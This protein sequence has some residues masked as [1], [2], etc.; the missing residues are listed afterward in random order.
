MA[1]FASSI[2]SAKDYPSLVI[3]ALQLVELLL[4]KVP[5]EYKHAFRREGVFHEIETL[6]ARSLV[7]PKVKDKDKDK[8]KDSNEATA[9]AEISTPSY[10]PPSAALVAIPGYKKPSSSTI[11]PDDAI[12]LRARVIK[13]KYLSS[14]EQDESDD[15][16]T[17]L[18]RLVARISDKAASE[19]DLLPSL[20]ELASL[21]ASPNTSVSSFELLQSG[22]VDSLLQFLADTDRIGTCSMLLCNTLLTIPSTSR[23]HT[24]PRYLF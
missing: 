24:S 4:N 1:S 21:F 22:V 14:E 10:L 5:D 3:G 20:V 7:S 18:R 15:V 23:Y 17:A 13:F 2:L 19:K 8:D 12:T 16:S 9:P 11:D 6:A